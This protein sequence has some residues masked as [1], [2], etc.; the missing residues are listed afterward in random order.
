M[1]SMR[2][3]RKET[4]ETYTEAPERERTTPEQQRARAISSAIEVWHEEQELLRQVT[5]VWDES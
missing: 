5:E 1:E 4:T 2:Y 3:G